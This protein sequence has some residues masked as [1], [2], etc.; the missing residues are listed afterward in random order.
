MA[1]SIEGRCPYADHRLVEFFLRMP[2]PIYKILANNKGVVRRFYQS[3]EVPVGKKKQP[4]FLP[5][6]RGFDARL[7]KFQEEVL[8][9]VKT[10][11]RSWFRPDAVAWFQEKRDGS[12]LIR[13]KQIMSLAILLFWLKKN[14]RPA[15]GRA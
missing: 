6:H 8:A 4:F 10:N 11:S 12:P 2:L 5:M 7:R 1:H 13:D 9:S 14:N 15:E 3:R